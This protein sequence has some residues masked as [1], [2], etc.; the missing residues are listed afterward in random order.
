MAMATQG[1]FCIKAVKDGK[2]VTAHRLH[3]HLCA[4]CDAVFCQSCDR[5][6]PVCGYWI[7][8]NQEEIRC[9]EDS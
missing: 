8:V 6:C 3:P 9:V 7:V 4:Y 5:A 2:V 1:G